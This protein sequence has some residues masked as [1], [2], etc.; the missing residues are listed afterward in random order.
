[1]Y[2]QKDEKC[3]VNL[4]AQSETDMTI[5]N[6]PVHISQKT[7]YPWDGDVN[8][9]VTPAKT[10][11]F[12]MMI[13]VPGWARNKPVP[14][15]LYTYLNPDNQPVKLKING[16]ETSYVIGEDGYIALNRKWK[17]GDAIELTFPMTVKRVIANDNV[18]DDQGKVSLERGPI[19]YCLEWP[20][21]NDNVLNSV[22]DDNVSVK[23]TFVK[24]ELNGIVRLEANAQASKRDNNQQVMLENKTL[25]AIP[26]YAWA[27]RGEGEMAVWIP[28]TQAVSKP[29][30]LPTISTKANVTASSPNKTLKSINDGFWPAN[31]ND[32]KVP[33]FS[34]WPKNNS[35]EWVEYQFEKP[36]T[37][38]SANVY[39]YDDGPWG[40]CRIPLSWK[41]QY[42]D[43]AGNWADVVATGTYVPVKDALNAITFKPVVAQNVRLVFQLP[44]KE[45]S[46]VYEFEVK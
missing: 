38:S 9:T 37:V 30:P 24:D 4:F 32:R 45:S 21:N 26:Y 43:A 41:V 19:V 42:K 14:S 22:L 20:D 15:D 39:W 1:M 2:A 36:E 13:R 11:A 44:E 5:L 35:T 31:S 16:K 33:F 8:I 18:A 7:G 10:K 25:T 34:L 17:K 6:N 46:A 27:N 12:T 23:A 29:L 40:G 28:R 3:Y